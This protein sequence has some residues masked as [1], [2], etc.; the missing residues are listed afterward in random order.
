MYRYLNFKMSETFVFGPTVIIFLSFGIYTNAAII[1]MYLL[2]YLTKFFKG[3]FIT[4]ISDY[5]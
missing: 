5:T 4:I 2:N 1:F 3:Y